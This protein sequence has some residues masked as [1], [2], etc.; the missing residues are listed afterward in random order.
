MNMGGQ[1]RGMADDRFLPFLDT[2]AMV[3]LRTQWNRPER[4]IRDKLGTVRYVLQ[5]DLYIK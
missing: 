2:E 4:R 5:H 3:T 1:H